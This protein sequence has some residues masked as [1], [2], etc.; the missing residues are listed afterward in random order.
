LADLTDLRKV[1]KGAVNQ[2]LK[3]SQSARRA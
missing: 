1:I 2:T 3:D